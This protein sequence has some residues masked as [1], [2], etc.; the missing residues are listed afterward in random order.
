MGSLANPNRPLLDRR[1]CCF[2]AGR[3]I[4]LHLTNSCNQNCVHCMRDSGPSRVQAADLERLKPALT[5]AVAQVR[6]EKVV[7]SGGEPA[8]VPNLSLVVSAVRDLKVRPSLCTNATAIDHRRA[9]ELAAAGLHAATVGIEGVGDGYRK[10]RRSRTGFDDALRGIVAL[11]HAGIRVT[12]NVT[13]C[14]DLI[15][16]VDTLADTLNGLHIST[17]SITSPMVAG[18]LKSIGGTGFGF[19]E[20]LEL[21]ER[22]VADLRSRMS[23]HVSVRIPRCDLASCPSGVSVF[24]MDASGRLSGCPD[25]GATNV[26]DL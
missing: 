13:F 16:S 12:V 18:R 23:I 5:E 25:V 10:I 1:D 24:A 6:P 22:F 2:S 15:D 14:R 21:F 7:I 19:S 17:V 9:I 26:L 8:L 4:L 20:D 3:L 11:T